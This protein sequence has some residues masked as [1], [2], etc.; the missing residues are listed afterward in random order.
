MKTCLIFASLALTAY[1][2][3]TLDTFTPKPLTRK[4]AF[5]FAKDDTPVYPSVLKDNPDY[6]HVH[7]M[8]KTLTKDDSGLS[9]TRHL[10]SEFVVPNHLRHQ[11]ASPK[12]SSKRERFKQL[13]KKIF[14]RCGLKLKR[15][16]LA[17]DHGLQKLSD[18]EKKFHNYIRDKVLG[19]A[20]KV[21][22]DKISLVRMAVAIGLESILGSRLVFAMDRAVGGAIV[23]GKK[24]NR[25]M[26]DHMGAVIGIAVGL[27]VSV[28]ITAGLAAASWNPMVGG[29]LGGAVGGGV[30]TVVAH[31]MTAVIKGNIIPTS[32]EEAAIRTAKFSAELTVSVT[33]GAAAGLASA[34]L[35]TGF[36]SLA[37]DAAGKTVGTIGGKAI[38]GISRMVVMEPVK[39]I[40]KHTGK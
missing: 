34:G 30:Q 18:K 29:A 20:Y 15:A 3:D 1:A 13:M 4:D 36:S 14:K 35:G 38:G 28:G 31:F 7:S 19:V 11:N 6:K 24:I 17:I 12:T 8:P 23:L 21:V 27:L 16:K 10:E 32:L 39:Q 2:A 9:P 22:A 25:F 33:V 5:R 26:I 37:A 40:I